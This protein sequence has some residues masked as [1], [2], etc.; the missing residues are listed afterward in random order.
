[1][2][3]EEDIPFLERVGQNEDL[4][5]SPWAVPD[6]SRRRVL[7]FSLILNAVLSVLCILLSG[8]LIQISSQAGKQNIG[9]KQTAEPYSPA[10][11]IIE[12]EH[13]SMV[14]N[15]TRFTGYPGAKWE[16]SMHELLAGTLIRISEDELRRHGSESIALK[17]GGYAAG[18]GV[19][20]DLHC[21]KK[22]K[23]W[24]YREHAYP[25]LAPDGEEFETIRFHA[26]HCLDFIRQGLMCR[27]D[28][29]MY[30][31]TW[32]DGERGLPGH[33]YHRTPDVQRCVNWDKAHNWMLGRA[34]NADDMVRP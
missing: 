4:K 17:D 6:K 21:V 5:D 32:G 19:G 14:A 30:T 8:R 31:L 11:A 2:S 15:D 3:V 27:L 1:M 12:Y 24:I 33:L 7:R 16:Q 18:L 23:Q 22:I 28:F 13:R 20:H 29:S 25:N 34:A 10:N 26:D 9:D